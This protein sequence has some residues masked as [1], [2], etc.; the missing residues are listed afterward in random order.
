M[1]QTLTPV[2]P[3]WEGMLRNLRREGTPERVFYFGCVGAVYV[4]DD[5]G[6]KTALMLAP[7]RVRRY[8]LPWHK[9]MADIAHEHGKLLLLHSC[10]H[11]YELMDEYLDHVKI[12]AKHSFEE[13]V[14]PV[15]EVKR[16]YGDRLALLG[17]MDVDLLARGDEESIRAKTREY[18]DVC[19]PGGG[20]FLGSGNWVSDYIPVDSY[21]TMLDEARK[22][23][24]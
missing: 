19:L 12:D 14:M 22:Y 8:I 24:S 9:R 17:G 13:N 16:R 3:D 5:L 7:D 23:L 11:M 21:L 18:L 20:Y 10:G 6:Y 15:T 1:S 4:S 2:D